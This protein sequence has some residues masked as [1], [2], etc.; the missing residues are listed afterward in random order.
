[1]VDPSQ[2]FIDLVAYVL[3][4]HGYQL[5]SA[6]C[7]NEA[8]ALLKQAKFDLILTEALDQSNPFD[9]DPNFLYEL[10]TVAP[11]TAMVLCSI[12]SSIEILQ[13]GTFGLAAVLRKP[14]DLSDLEKTMVDL[15]SE[16]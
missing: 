4:E 3:D 12:Y 5:K 2:E 11:Q 1:M 8:L 14:I 7:L 9:F 6:S 13:P 16:A 15:L 10:K